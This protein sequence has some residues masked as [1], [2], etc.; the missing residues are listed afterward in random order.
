MSKQTKQKSQVVVV[1]SLLALLCV[2]VYTFWHTGALLARYIAPAFLGYV[3]AAGVELTVISMSVQFRDILASPAK[4][5][6]VKALFMFVFLAALAVSALANVSEGFRTAYGTVL[7]STTFRTVDILVAVIGVS[8]T[9]L[10]SLV[11]MSLAELLGDSFNVVLGIADGLRPERTA[12]IITVESVNTAILAQPAP[13]Q[14]PAPTL[15]SAREA[16]K[17]GAEQAKAALAVFLAEH[18][19]ATQA[20]A[21]A[22]VG[23]SRAWVSAQVNRINHR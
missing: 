15:E 4:H 20:E 18:P 5:W 9:G 19:N 23:R 6:T 2:L 11:V 16:R 14:L 17:I 7:D 21:G 12:P 8:A 1:L 13:R 22:A 3:A 10:L